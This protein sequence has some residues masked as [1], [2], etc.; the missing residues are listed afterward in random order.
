MKLKPQFARNEV[1]IAGNLGWQCRGKK[2]VGHQSSALIRNQMMLAFI[3]G[4]LGKQTDVFF[5]ESSRP[6][7]FLSNFHNIIR[8]SLIVERRKS[9]KDL[10][11]LVF[12]LW[13]L[14]FDAVLLSTLRVK[15]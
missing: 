6:G 5:R 9:N 15:G 13:P 12:G 7:T 10:W 3:A 2:P 14:D 11:T 4:E 8:S 1:H